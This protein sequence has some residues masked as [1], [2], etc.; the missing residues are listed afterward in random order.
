MKR[1]VYW[2]RK[3]PRRFVTLSE[4]SFRLYSIDDVEPTLVTSLPAHFN[5]FPEEVCFCLVLLN[6]D[7]TVNVCI[8]TVGADLPV[9]SFCSN[10]SL[11]THPLII[12]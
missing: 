1:N 12:N 3:Q 8:L 2:L 7:S 4:K 6:S 5:Q 10:C 9:Y 11:V